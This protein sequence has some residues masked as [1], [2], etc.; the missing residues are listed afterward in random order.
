[1]LNPATGDRLVTELFSV[2]I[3]I[4]E[5]TFVTNKAKKLSVKK[6]RGLREHVLLSHSRAYPGICRAAKPQITGSH[7]RLSGAAGL[8]RA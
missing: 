5:I 2:L 8:G 7:A 6:R 3:S 1:M 4:Y